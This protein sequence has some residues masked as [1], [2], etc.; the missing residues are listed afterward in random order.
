M[1]PLLVGEVRHRTFSPHLNARMWSNGNNGRSSFVESKRSR[2]LQPWLV[3]AALCFTVLFGL[4]VSPAGAQDDDSTPS[5]LPNT[6]MQVEASPEGD[7]AVAELPSTG[8]VVQASP[9]DDAV[10]GLPETGMVIQAT[11][12]DDGVSE[13][14]STGTGDD[15]TSTGML[16][17]GLVVVTSLLGI[18]AVASRRLVARP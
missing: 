15:S 1:R 18:G 5:S 4:S 12:D 8:M 9:E 6:G 7:G 2:L 11:P 14:P 17:A 3:A 16:V 10:S 13:L